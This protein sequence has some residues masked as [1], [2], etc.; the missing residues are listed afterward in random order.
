MLLGQFQMEKLL[1]AS[2]QKGLFYTYFASRGLSPSGWHVKVS[3]C[4]IASRLNPASSRSKPENLS[5][6]CACMLCMSFFRQLQSCRHQTV[7]EMQF[8]SRASG[9]SK[10]QK[11]RLSRRES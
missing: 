5:S 9:C 1:I 10:E 11:L 6:Q 3:Y 2:E 4:E 7:K 8:L